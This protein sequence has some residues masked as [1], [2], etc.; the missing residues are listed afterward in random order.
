MHFIYVFNHETIN[1]IKTVNISISCNLPLP[2]PLG[3]PFLL[4]LSLWSSQNHDLLSVAE[5]DF[6][7]SSILYKWNH[8]ICGL[9]VWLLSLNMM[10]SK[11][12]HV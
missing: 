1:K 7:I 12:I 10:F 5:D 6:V 11:F 8:T 9:C 4:S 3:N 2:V